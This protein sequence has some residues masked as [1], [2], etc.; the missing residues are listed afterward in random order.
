M[1]SDVGNTYVEDSVRDTHSIFVVESKYPA[2]EA[3]FLSDKRIKDLAEE[4]A[5]ASTQ[6]SELLC[7]GT[8]KPPSTTEEQQVSYTAPSP[9][10]PTPCLLDDKVGNVDECVLFD[11][12]EKVD[13]Y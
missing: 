4:Q 10:P 2:R 12:I 5:A 1:C 3:E 6:K 13:S 9:P 7:E 11:L 8:S